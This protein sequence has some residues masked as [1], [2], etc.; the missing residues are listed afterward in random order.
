MK[1][2]SFPVRCPFWL[3]GQKAYSM[4]E[5]LTTFV[6]IVFVA[7]VILTS[8]PRCIVP[9]HSHNPD[10][11]TAWDLRNAIGAYYSEYRHYPTAIA[12]P[13]DASA[14]AMSDSILMGVL[15][16]SEK[17][18]HNDGLNPRGIPFFSGADAKPMGNGRFRRGIQFNESGGGSLW[19]NWGNHYRIVMDLDQDG[20]VPLPAFAGGGFAPVSVIVWTPGKDGRDDTAKDNVVTW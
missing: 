12:G 17:V 7:M 14:P 10:G 5:W 19:D 3:R 15:L 11:R 18:I 20:R 16:P 1:I 2:R 8:I 9:G 4:G 6:G 13:E